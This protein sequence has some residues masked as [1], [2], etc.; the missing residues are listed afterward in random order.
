ME[1]ARYLRLPAGTLRSWVV[2]RSY[3]TSHGHRA[4]S[5]LVRP[6]KRQPVTLSFLNLL[7]SHVLRAL[8]S[9]HGVSVPDLRKALEY[10]EREL[11]IERLL[12]R[13]DLQT[14]A[15]RI[16]LER[17]GELIDL[18]NSGQLALRKVL[19]AHLRRVE[20]DPS[21]LPIRFYPFLSSDNA[22]E[23]RIIAIDP[24]VAFGRPV[25]RRAGV[26]TQTIVDRLDAGEAVE[27]VAADYGITAAD[28]EQAVVYER[29]A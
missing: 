14:D 21:R 25:V 29:A 19:E 26:S 17:Y 8:R 7:E 5:P 20:W 24:G 15:G 28:V 1:A 22:S 13:Q 9:E 2:G 16:F 23:Q 3:P 11:K 27:D 6:A 18:S 4:F 12:L 10:A